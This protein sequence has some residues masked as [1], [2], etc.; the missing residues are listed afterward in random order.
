ML[1]SSYLIVI[2]E[3]DGVLLKVMVIITTG[4]VEYGGITNAFMNYYRNLDFKDLLIDVVSCGNY[5]ETL[6]LEVRKHGGKCYTVPLK[7]KSLLQYI[8]S[9]NRLLAENYDVVDVHGNS[10][11]MALE[12][13]L[14]KKNGVK[15][16]MAHCLNSRTDY[17]FLHFVLKQSFNR[18]CN[19]K[20]ACTNE[21]GLFLYDTS[22][23]KILKN[24]IETEKYR[25]SKTYR[26][27]I[28]NKY[29][30]SDSEILLGTVGK[31][32]KQKNHKFI[33]QVFCLIMKKLNNVKLMIV[34]DGPLRDE[35]EQQISCFHI[36]D[37]VILTGML[38]NVI[39]YY[40]AFDIYL[41]PSLFEGLSLA[42]LE[43]KCSGL[44]GIA[45]R[46]IK[47]EDDDTTDFIRYCNLDKKTWCTNIIRMCN[48]K[49]YLN[50]EINSSYVINTLKR[51]GYDSKENAVLLRRLYFGSE[52]SERKSNEK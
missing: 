12:M 15:N 16:R 3:Q 39:P 38:T 31:I 6:A 18:I 23:Y 32:N 8:R 33:I 42:L 4:F 26:T 7:Q 28:R 45:S 24:T 47:T 51:E 44:I 30:I 41:F 43:A 14:A 36:K 40:S 34:G 2:K 27:Q 49:E 20:T 25:Y 37:K 9:I 21:A 29:G 5:D 10:A 52:L 1:L 11:T 22:D 19:I 50:R 46:D 13:Y 35:I 48:E 17:P